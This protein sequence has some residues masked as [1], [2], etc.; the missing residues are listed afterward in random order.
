VMMALLGAQFAPLLLLSN[1]ALLR[2][3]LSVAPRRIAPS[4]APR[5]AVS[6]PGFGGGGGSADTGPSE[7]V[8]AYYRLLGLAEDASYDEINVAH[9]GL[10]DKYKGDVKMT[11]KLQVAKDKILDDRL[12]QRMSGA[13]KSAVAESPFDRKE[14][15]EPFIKIP[16]FL[17]DVMELPTR[18]LLQKNALVFGAIGF[19]PVISKSW[20]ATSV[21]LG[22]A[23]SLY[24]LYNRGVPESSSSEMGM[25]MRPPKAK[26]LIL[27]TGFTLLAGALGATVSQLVYGFLARFMAQQS[28]I[29]LCTSIF[30]GFTASIFKVQDEYS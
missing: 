27:A 22:F 25:E 24:L 26:P 29:G 2:P 18:A 30:F 7:E 15:P 21:G 6:L 20:A 10:A 11:I 17:A 23:V 1:P 12:R 16:P 28:V 8:L 14:A 4:I 3:P 13:L 19:L 9:D 5:M